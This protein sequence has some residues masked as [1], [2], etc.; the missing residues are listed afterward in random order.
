VANYGS[1]TAG[2]L[3]GNGDGTF[4]AAVTYGSGGYSAS[5]LAIADV[6]GDGKPDLLVANQYASENGGTGTVGVLLNTGKSTS[7]I[8]FSPTSLTF[9]TQLV[10]TTS[11]AQPVTVTNTGTGV[12]TIKGISVKGAFEQ[13]NN[14]PPNLSAGSKC[15]ITVKFHPKTKGILDG[16]VNVTDNAPGSPQE[17]PLTGTGTFVHLLPATLHMGKQPVGTKSLP[18]RM[19]LTNKGNVAL[20]IISIAITG[21]DSGD[22]AETNNCGNQVGPGASCF[23]KVM[24][25]PLAKGVR[26]ADVSVSDD[27]GGS[28]QQAGLIGTGT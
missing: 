2:V 21:T 26:A 28:P 27:G 24:F 1:S 7:K 14:C 22:F 8:T 15:T 18:K 12:L 6:N 5:S 25:K 9:P 19:T 16:S 23:I 17:V 10:Y 3:L 13:T 4:R 11:A 20:N